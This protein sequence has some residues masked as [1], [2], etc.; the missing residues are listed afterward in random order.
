[1]SDTAVASKTEG[2]RSA[3]AMHKT[4]VAI[5]GAG[6]GGYVAAIRL[7]QLGKKVTVIDRGYPGGVC[8]NWGCIPS[9]ALI[10]AADVVDEIKHAESIG[11]K[12]QGEPEIDFAKMIAW[13]D[14]VVKRLTGGVR[15]LLQHHKCEWLEG[16]ARLSGPRKIEV[17]TANGVETVEAQNIMIA[18]GARPIDIPGFESDGENIVHSRGALA[19]QKLPKSLVI[20]G[21]GVIGV[22]MGTLFAKLGTKVTIVELM[23]QILPGTDPEL[24]K[25]VERGLKKRKVDLRLGSKASKLEKKGQ[26]YAVTIEGKKGK[27]EVVECEKI[28]VGVGFR[29]NTKDLG[30][31]SAGVK[32]DDR[33][34]IPV[35][36]YQRTNVSHIY[37]IG[38]V[39]GPP[40]LAH[41][42]SKEGLIAAG[43]IAAEA[44]TEND[45]R[46][47]PAVVFCDPEIATVGMSEEEAKKAGHEVHIGRFPMQASGRALTMQSTE[48]LVKIITNAK[49]DLLLGVGIVARGASDLI[50]EAALAIEMGAVAEDLALTVHPHPTLS[51]SVMEAAEAVA[52]RAIHSVSGKK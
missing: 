9:K 18:T 15:S 30:L 5:I 19:W 35:D 25:V 7:G 20:I 6:P 50:S 21:G 8:L 47:M 13:K 48:G 34:F 38:D 3:S 28:L 24:T 40:F 51:E 52:D 17:R 11:I 29:P 31:E 41:K 12:I 4:D 37:A 27:T 46:A 14:D 26:G 39:I 43:V 10:H 42:A 45:V 49:T 36:K 44:G 33:G 1:M 32:L 22:E 2:A 23:D 16:E